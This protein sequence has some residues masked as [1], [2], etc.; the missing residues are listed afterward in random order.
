MMTNN[1]FLRNNHHN[2]YSNKKLSFKN[3][4]CTDCTQKKKE[5]QHVSELGDDP[6][7]ISNLGYIEV[8]SGKYPI[9]VTTP[10]MV[11]PFG[12]NRENNQLTLQFTNL[13]TDSEMKS[14]FEFIQELELQQMKYLGLD[15]DE[16]ELYLSQIRYD[17][18]GKYD[19]NL[20]IKVP[21]VHSSNKYDI[22]IRTKDTCCSITNIYKFSKLKCD[23]Y[24]DKI[25]KFNEKYVCKWKVKNILIV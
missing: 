10:T 2:I 22:D 4:L 14:F 23:I 9:Y 13:K 5:Y 20:L 25:W 24:I 17:K 7:N 15:E 16:V 19:P 21:W 18:K 11:C 3:F 6:K 8:F 12:F 1:D